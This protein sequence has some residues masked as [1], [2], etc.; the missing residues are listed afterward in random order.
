MI[1][2]VYHHH[3]NVSIGEMFYSH[4]FYEVYYKY[5]S[6][7]KPEYWGDSYDEYYKKLYKDKLDKK[8]E[9]KLKW[10]D[11]MPYLKDN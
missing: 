3:E 6:K 7:K 8:P 11:Y 1:D 10:K 5:F 9:R 4:S 2:R